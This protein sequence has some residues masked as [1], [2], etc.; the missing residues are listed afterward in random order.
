MAA[1]K[2]QSSLVPA[3]G[4]QGEIQW[5]G[6]SWG[7]LLDHLRNELQLDA[8]TDLAPG[9]ILSSLVGSASTSAALLLPGKNSAVG[10]ATLTWPA[11][12]QFS[13]NLGVTLAGATGTVTGV[14]TAAGNVNNPTFFDQAF[15]TVFAGTGAVVIQAKA[16]GNPGATGTMAIA[17]LLWEV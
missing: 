10:S 12:S 13:N 5:Q 8:N 1:R 17:Y 2:L 6:Y 7:D 3:R 15:C 9:T 11:G 16:G 4:P 14:A